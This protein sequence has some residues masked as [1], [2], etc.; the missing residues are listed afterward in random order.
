MKVLFLMEKFAAGN[1]ACGDSN[2]LHNFV[3]SL[4]T[5]GHE[6]HIIY[7]DE[8]VRKTMSPVDSCL[9]DC[10]KGMDMVFF[11][12][13]FFYP[14]N[15]S[16]KTIKELTNHIPVVCVWTDFCKQRELSYENVA[17]LNLIIDVK[18]TGEDR[19]YSSFTPQSPRIF[20]DANLIR[21][22]ELSFV[23]CVNKPERVHYLNRLRQESFFHL[24]ET[25][26]SRRETTLD[27]EDYA[28][29]FQRS[30]ISLNFSKSENYALQLKGRIFEIVHCGAM[31]M[32]DQNDYL[33]EFLEPG[34]EYI[35]F[36]NPEDLVNKCNY[37]LTHEDD[38]LEIAVAGHKKVVEKY[39]NEIFWNELF[40]KVNL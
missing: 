20:H 18:H 15:P 13:L 14:F 9:M 40:K 7:F 34:K 33:N 16:S 36:S 1:P 2:S 8:H 27:P 3:D 28:K 12:Y 26:L 17:T 24:K 6:A 32:S 31:L 37:F 10:I 25:D 11:T 35:P 4:R 29:I 39:N 21:D 19:Y 23:G 38:R 30:K 22:I 5:L